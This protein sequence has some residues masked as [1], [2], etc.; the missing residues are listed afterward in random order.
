MGSVP[1]RAAVLDRPCEE[2]ELVFYKDVTGC[3]PVIRIGYLVLYVVL[4]CK[5][6]IDTVGIEHIIDKQLQITQVV[7][8]SFKVD[9]IMELY[10]GVREGVCVYSSD[11]DVVRPVYIKY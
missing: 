7:L 2:L 1:A 8:L 10:C 3:A 11:E 4:D 9:P 5:H 6:S